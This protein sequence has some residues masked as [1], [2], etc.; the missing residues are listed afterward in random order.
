MIVLGIDPGLEGGLA[1]REGDGVI[2][3][4]MPVKDGS[5]DLD[6][7]Y[8]FLHPYARA[9]TK[10]YLEMQS[11]RP[12]QSGQFKIGRGF[13]Q[14]ETILWS[15]RIPTV[16]VEP[17]DWSKH[18]PHGVEERDLKK[19]KPMIKKARSEIASRLYPGIDLRRTNK[20]KVPDEGLVDALLI[21]D[22]GWKQMKGILK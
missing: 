3:E 1:I 6:D 11:L 7:I 21:A 4:P 2:L 16:I 19:R 18:Y 5:L 17:K 20:C 10:S 15:L 12:M 14:L 13:G 8:H 9:V 22:F